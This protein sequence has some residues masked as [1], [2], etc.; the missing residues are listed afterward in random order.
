MPP[1]VNPQTEN[2]EQA[3]L[4]GV[5]PSQHQQPGSHANGVSS[6]KINEEPREEEESVARAALRYTLLILFVIAVG[7]A[8]WFI[9]RQ[10]G[11]KDEPSPGGGREDD[12][13]ERDIIEWKSQL[14]GW[15]SAVVYRKCLIFHPFEVLYWQCQLAASLTALSGPDCV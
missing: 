6:P 12:E 2:D 4:L 15:T 13:R 3:P 8:A 9:N 11:G 14:I 1:R 10:R 7:L 5:R